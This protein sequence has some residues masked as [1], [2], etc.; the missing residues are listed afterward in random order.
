M[1]RLAI[2]FMVALLALTLSPVA[3]IGAQGR[4]VRLTLID[5]NG[6]GEDGSAQLTDQG[7][8]STKVELLMLNVPEG[9]VQPAALR[10][11]SCA[12]L[13]AAVAYKLEDVKESKSTTTVKVAL[14][15]LLK[16][17]YAISVHKSPSDAL[18]ISCG[19]LP[20]AAAVSGS[21]TLDQ[22]MTELL[23]QANELLATVKKKEADGSQ[24]AYNLYHATF[25]AHE[26]EIQAKSNTTW[27]ALED[28][29]R[30]IRDAL[31]GTDWAKSE[32]EAAG[33][34]AAVTK[35]QGEL[36]GGTSGALAATL[37]KLTTAARDLARETANKDKA[38]SDRAYTAYHDLFAANEDAIRA[39]SPETWQ[40]MED[41]MR[42]VRDALAANDLTKAGT[43][44][45][46]LETTIN[47]AMGGTATTSS[48][49]NSALASVLQKLQTAAADLVR[50]TT[51]KDK[52]GS[53]RAYDA[54][55]AL[56]AANEDAIRAQNMEAWQR[57]ENVM[58]EVRDALTAGDLTKAAT[59]ANEL[60]T[61]VNDAM[62]AMGGTANS[63]PTSGN[64]TL[65]LMLGALAG[66]AMALLIVG[67]RLQ[68]S[69]R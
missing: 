50:E 27:Q 43:A 22:V 9:D 42:E 31:Q 49:G 41:L 64:G 65:L 24:N 3:R 4:V 39:A 30:G 23:N 59:A 2:I 63:L 32:E 51:N 18:V 45:A 5:E 29:M 69:T 57:L 6:S 21:M 36:A 20:S 26:G 38:G 19:N 28:A 1:K 17:K 58:N 14:E 40:K 48:G 66:L 44:A 10:K 47:S 53:Q 46:E 16:E 37:G 56:F 13:D 12:A 8:G 60:Q 52:E 7:D 34:V 67:L 15:E 62:R 25:A 11:G 61:E 54:Y 35:A 55:H 33:L 68:R